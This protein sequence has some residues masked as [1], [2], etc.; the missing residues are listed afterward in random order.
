MPPEIRKSSSISQWRITDEFFSSFSRL[1]H[2]ANRQ[3]DHHPTA[4]WPE[5]MRTSTRARGLDPSRPTPTTRTTA[6]RT[7][8]AV[9]WPPRR[10]LRDPP[11]ASATRSWSGTAKETLRSLKRFDCFSVF[12]PVGLIL[13]RH[14]PRRCSSVGW[15]F[16]NGPSLVQL[17]WHGFESRRRDIR[18]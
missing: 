14:G 6:S 9:R 4:G 16:F 17:D 13:L 12:C 11:P 2:S 18:C 8:A 15:A 7:A 5:A 10:P 3:L 1:I